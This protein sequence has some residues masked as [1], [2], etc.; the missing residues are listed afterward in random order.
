MSI[1]GTIPSSSS[2][3]KKKIN[4]LMLELEKI[5][6][7]IKRV[8][9]NAREKF[10]LTIMLQLLVDTQGRRYQRGQYGRIRGRQNTNND[11]NHRR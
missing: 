2:A 6:I 5:R 7:K 8:D 9:T 4:V 11:N 1:K 10:Q 3:R